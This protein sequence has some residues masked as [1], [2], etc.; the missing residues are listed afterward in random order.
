MSQFFECV[1]D[2]KLSFILSCGH[3]VHVEDAVKLMHF[4]L[5]P[6]CHRILKTAD[7]LV[8]VDYLREDGFFYQ[9][10]QEAK[11]CEMNLSER[12]RKNTAELS[13]AKRLR[14]ARLSIETLRGCMEGAMSSNN[15]HLE[16]SSEEVDDS[17]EYSPPSPYYIPSDSGEDDD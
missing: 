13:P 5:C 6:V 4:K 17:L 3:R 15:D 14:R 10:G 7:I 1:D 12:K 16:E 8:L 2:R 9:N 11:V